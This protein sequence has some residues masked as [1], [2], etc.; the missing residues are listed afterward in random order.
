LLLPNLCGSIVT[1]MLVDDAA[2]YRRAMSHC[3][4]LV[5]VHRG[6]GG[7]APGRRD[8]EVSL[9]RA[10]IVMT[11]AAWQA[12]I[13]DMVKSMLIASQPPVGSPHT[14][15]YNVVAGQVRHAV[16]QFSTPN[17]E[18]TQKLMRSA[19][20]D[21]SPHWTW[22]QMGGQGVGLITITPV[23]ASTRIREWLRVRHDIAHGR[24][25]ISPVSVLQAVRQN[26]GPAAGWYPTIRLV[27]AEQCMSFFRRLCQLTASGLG[28]QIGQQPGEW[29]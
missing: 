29:S 19:G 26:P 16:A 22:S 4:N 23:V 18:N 11:V 14:N 27:D 7:A 1:T 10:V 28:A 17:A 8:Q 21:P 25:E 15:F 13:Q 6:H 5:E 20:F 3:V 2:S 24:A 12:A 9:N